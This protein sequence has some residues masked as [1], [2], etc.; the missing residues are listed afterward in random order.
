M[1]HPA[2]PPCTTVDR[3]VCTPEGVVPRE[4]NRFVPFSSIV[5][6]ASEMLLPENNAPMRRPERVHCMWRTLKSHLPWSVCT[7]TTYPARSWNDRTG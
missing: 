3:G 4:R 2:R 1:A 7:G 5:P 6:A